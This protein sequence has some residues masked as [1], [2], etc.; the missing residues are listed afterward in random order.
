MRRALRATAAVL[1]FA[2]ATAH[3]HCD[4]LDGPVVG[5]AREA[6]DTGNVNAYVE[7]YV[8]YVHYV[9][10]LHQAAGTSAERGHESTEQRGTAHRH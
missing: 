7:A 5:A 1:L 9:E 3:A 6:L 2:A 4:T 8:P 10:R